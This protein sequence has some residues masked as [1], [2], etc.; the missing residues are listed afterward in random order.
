MAQRQA[1]ATTPISTRFEKAELEIL[2][3]AADKKQWSIAQLVRVGAYEKAVNI[4][5][6]TGHLVP[7]VRSIL[8]QV[9]DQLVEP[10]VVHTRPYSVGEARMDFNAFEH[11]FCQSIDYEGS[12][13]LSSLDDAALERFLKAI[14]G[15]GSELA[16]LLS[17]EINR[18]NA[19]DPHL[20]SEMIDPT[21]QA[22]KNVPSEPPKN[23]EGVAGQSKSKRAKPKRKAKRGKGA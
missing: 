16:D 12:L 20:V 13:R 21:L 17:D 2:K 11:D 7:A 5:N 1:A 19:S 22:S 14:R 6:A 15:L 10:K 8:G 23:A 4:L 3:R 18:R 9:I